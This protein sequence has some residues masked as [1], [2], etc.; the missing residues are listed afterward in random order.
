MGLPHG[1]GTKTWTIDETEDN[2]YKIYKGA[3]VEG[4]MQGMGE[5][6]MSQNEV[7]FGEFTNG[8]PCGYGTRKWPNGDIYEGDFKNGF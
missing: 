7:Y 5:L 2:Q 8:Y 4:K 3:W 6:V 1:Q